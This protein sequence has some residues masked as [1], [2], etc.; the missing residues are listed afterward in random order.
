VVGLSKGIQLPTLEC[1]ICSYSGAQQFLIQRA[2]ESTTRSKNPAGS[3]KNRVDH[4]CRFRNWP[5]FQ[6]LVAKTGTEE[7]AFRSM[8]KSLLERRFAEP[9]EVAEAILFLASDA[10][11]YIT[12]TDLIV[13]GGYTL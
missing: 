12:G 10:S 13:D 9:E 8:S 7:A 1:V 6:E 3:R 2:G 4:G 5:F 11:R